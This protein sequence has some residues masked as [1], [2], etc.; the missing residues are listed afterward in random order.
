[1]AD[2]SFDEKNCQTY[3]DS[4]RDHSYEKKNRVEKRESF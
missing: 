3:G 2:L 1:M 4:S